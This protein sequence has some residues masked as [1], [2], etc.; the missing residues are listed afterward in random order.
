MQMVAASKMRRAQEQA[1]AARPYA[2]KLRTV[3]SALV[4]QGAGQG[5]VVHPLLEERPVRSVLLLE[6]TPDRG[7]AGGLPSS[8]NRASAQFILAQQVPCAVI[9]SGRKGRDF[10]VRTSRDLRATFLNMSDRPTMA[11][12]LPITSMVGRMYTDGEVDQVHLA[13]TR[14][15]NTLVQEP[16]VIRLLPVDTSQLE[17]SVAT[18]DYLYEPDPDAVFGAMLPRFLEVQVYEAFLEN[19]ASEQSARMV[20][21]RN[22]TEAAEDMIESLTLELNK[23][24]QAMITAELLD[25]IGGVAALEA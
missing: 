22:A 14:Y 5:D 8:I 21:M 6:I 20:A 25:L 17:E 23:A 11:D 3:L 18:V 19:N 12:T 4:A 16:V 2:E 7:L 9:T 10:M 1:V 15:V 13:Y 24:R